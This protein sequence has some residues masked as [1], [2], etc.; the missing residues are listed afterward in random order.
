MGL[1]GSLP[2]LGRPPP[3]C[4]AMRRAVASMDWHSGKAAGP[5]LLEA[6]KCS[7]SASPCNFAPAAPP[8]PGLTCT[9]PLRGEL[10]GAASVPRAVSDAIDVPARLAH[11]QWLPRLAFTQAF[12]GATPSAPDWPRHWAPASL[13]CACRAPAN[14]S[15]AHVTQRFP[16]SEPAA[17]DTATGALVALLRSLPLLGVRPRRTLLAVDGCAPPLQCICLRRGCH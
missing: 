10:A 8:A 13:V 9:D 17:A 3:V 14:A 6:E 1:C 15:A 4:A 11:C 2:S 5:Q 12:D 16:G 7:G